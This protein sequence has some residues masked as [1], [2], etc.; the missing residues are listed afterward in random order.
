[1]CLQRVGRPGEV[2]TPLPPPVIALSQFPSSLVCQ[3]PS[4]LA[5][6]VG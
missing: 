6:W 5:P 4:F 2:N 1:M 3:S